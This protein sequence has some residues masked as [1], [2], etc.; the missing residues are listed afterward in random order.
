MKDKYR[1]S[2]VSNIF[3]I[4]EHT[5]RYYDQ[6]NLFKPSFRDFNNY[7]YYEHSQLSTLSL[8]TK[9]KELGLTL[10]DIRIYLNTKNMNSYENMLL[11][12]QKMINDKIETLL[13]IKE[14]N[15][16]LL[17]KIEISK[18]VYK[19]NSFEI[20]RIPKRYA[21]KVDEEFSI[22]DLY[23]EIK[24][25][26]AAFMNDISS[27]IDC[28]KGNIFIEINHNN[29]I[30]NDFSVYEGI[31]FF[32]NNYKDCKGY[33][34]ISIEESDYAIAYHVGE[35][36]YLY[37]TYEMLCKYIKSNGYCVIGNSIETA[38]TD[39]TIVNNPKEFITEIQIPIST[40]K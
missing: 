10:D 18:R 20:K 29:I 24:K 35:Y 6:I 19:N 40:G 12:A 22:K 23:T 3:N 8:I 16:R 39:R 17:K 38:I 14:D 32:I 7:R 34:I 4:S 37:K 30:S 28:H 9:L 5:L 15:S 11:E 33:N 2:E 21:Y 26:Y 27:N 1:V 31:G 25:L 36:A 13:Q